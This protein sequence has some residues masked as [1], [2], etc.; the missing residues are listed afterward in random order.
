MTVLSLSPPPVL[1]YNRVR[2]RAG[3]AVPGGAGEA[4][5]PALAFGRFG[6]GATLAYSCDPAPHWGCNFVFWEGFRAFWKAAFA[7]LLE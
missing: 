3:C 2:L 7:R 5:D 6:R 1:G 4:G